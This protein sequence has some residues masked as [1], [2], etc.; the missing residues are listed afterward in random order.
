MPPSSNEEL[1]SLGPF[2]LLARRLGSLAMGLAGGRAERIVLSYRGRLADHDT[3]L[4]TV[5][6]LNG[7]FQGRTEQPVNVV[8]AALVAAERGI[9]VEEQSD[10]SSPDYTS[11]VEVSLRANGE[12]TTVAGTTFGGE[13]RHW[14]VGALGFKIEIELA[15]LMVFFQYDDRPGVIGHVGTL[16][17]RAGIN[18]ANM[19][20][21]RTN[22]GGRAVMALSIDTPAPPRRSS[23]SSAPPASTTR[24]SSASVTSRVRDGL[25]LVARARAR[26]RAPGCATVGGATARRALREQREEPE[27]DAGEHRDRKAEPFVVADVR[28]DHHPVRARAVRRRGSSTGGRTRRRGRTTR[29]RRAR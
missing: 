7:V 28:G 10:R 9:A 13:S 8:N 18:I 16:F 25:V 2:A 23:R 1:E 14:L 20:V 21:S 17:G 6:A 29:R 19:A 11:L 27:R 22:E 3:R 12:E 15:P 5:A 24:A 26:G 4:L